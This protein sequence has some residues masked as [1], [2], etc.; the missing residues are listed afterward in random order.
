M[1]HTC[2]DWNMARRRHAHYPPIWRHCGSS[3]RT[4]LRMARIAWGMHTAGSVRGEIYRPDVDDLVR[5]ASGARA[6][7]IT[8]LIIN[9]GLAG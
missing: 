8:V 5:I 7:I 9:P 2:R 3:Y 6:M 1:S 4:T